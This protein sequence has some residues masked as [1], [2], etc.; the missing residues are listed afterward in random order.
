M[1]FKNQN[2]L[3][4]FLQDHV[5]TNNFSN[6]KFSMND[7]I[8]ISFYKF[9][10][11]KYPEYLF[12]GKCY[13]VVL[14]QNKNQFDQN[15]IGFCFSYSFRGLRKFI[16]NTKSDGRN[17]N[18]VVLVEALIDGIDIYQLYKD[19][20]DENLIESHPYMDEDEILAINIH[21]ID[22]IQFLTEKQFN[23]LF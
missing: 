12:H 16:N 6:R 4:F 9:I 3:I 15:D 5:F 7:D 11:K 21:S 20:L 18:Y 17:F 23:Q 8:F 19:L 10:E 1:E 2:D 14:V 13:R 22:S